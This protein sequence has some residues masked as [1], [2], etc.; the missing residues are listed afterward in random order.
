[1]QEFCGSHEF[2]ATNRNWYFLPNANCLRLP[3]T[4]EDSSFDLM[5]MEIANVPARAV[6]IASNFVALH[7]HVPNRGN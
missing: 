5:E 2:K 7:V 4:S 6:K 3:M 1:M